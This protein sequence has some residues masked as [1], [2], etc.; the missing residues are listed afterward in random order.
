MVL[1]EKIT[2]MEWQMFQEVQNEGGRAGCQDDY[3]TFHIMRTSQ[4]GMWSE[5]LRESYAADLEEAC[6]KKQNLLSYKYAYMMERTAPQA[7]AGIA[8]WLP[9]VS[10]EKQQLVDRIVASQMNQA[11]LLAKKYPKFILTARPL[12]REQD[13]QGDTSF[14]TYLWGELK[15]YSE[16]TLHLYLQFLGEEKGQRLME[17]IMTDTAR[18]YGY[19]SL[20]EAEAKLKSLA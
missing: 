8:K 12:T 11:F 20:E 5:A 6:E 7:Y 15:T 18:Q 1:T 17:N 16:K 4:L 10:E 13:G 19:A 2:E 14:E 3:E 9:P